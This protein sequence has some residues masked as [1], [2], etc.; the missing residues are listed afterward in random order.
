MEGRNWGIPYI[1]FSVYNI[2]A[3]LQS[4]LI[5]MTY[6]ARRLSKDYIP[7]DDGMSC[8]RRSVGYQIWYRSRRRNVNNHNHG[9]KSAD[10]ISDISHPTIKWCPQIAVYP[11]VVAYRWRRRSLPHRLIYPV[12]IFKI[13]FWRRDGTRYSEWKY[14]HIPADIFKLVV[15]KK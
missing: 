5:M 14:L 8:L 11:G 10:H 9:R 1:L 3:P 13:D 2:A 6:D 12:F 15:L 7:T 4:Y